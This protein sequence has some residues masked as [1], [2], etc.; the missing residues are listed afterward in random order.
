MKL[1]A[2]ESA[3]KELSIKYR[4]KTKKEFPNICVIY[5]FLREDDSVEL[6]IHAHNISVPLGYNG[7]INPSTT[8]VDQVL[9]ERN[10]S[11]S[12]EKDFS[13]DLA[14]VVK[15]VEKWLREKSKA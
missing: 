6:T 8:Y 15:Y 11:S 13:N 3:I 4:R 1:N 2:I 9:M 7:D 5:E 12:Q 10:G 14:G